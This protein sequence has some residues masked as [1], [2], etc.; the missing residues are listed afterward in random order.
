[1]SL[2]NLHWRDHGSNTTSLVAL[3]LT[4]LEMMHMADGYAR[5]V[6]STRLR[7][8]GQ[9]GPDDETWYEEYDIPFKLKRAGSHLFGNQNYP[10]KR[11][12]VK[13]EG[14]DPFGRQ[15]EACLGMNGNVNTQSYLP[16]QRYE[17]AQY[18]SISPQ[19]NRGQPT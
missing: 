15:G 14:T 18:E 11:I 7:N 9:V 5:R 1:V 2:N 10:A 3:F 6:A 12:R 13:L 8:E 19:S 4:H 16:M 17:P